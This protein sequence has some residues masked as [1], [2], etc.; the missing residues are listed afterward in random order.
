MST[1]TDPVDIYSPDWYASG[2][3]HGTF[4]GLRRQGAVHWQDMPDEPGFWAVLRHAELAHVAKHPELFSA[5][6]Q[7]IMLEDL[8]PEQLEMVRHML[9]AMDPPTHTAYRRPI[10]PHFTAK[11]IS[12]MED[13]VRARCRGILDRVDGEVDLV[14]DVAGP[15]P[16]QMITDIMG[17]PE[18]DTD[19][20]Q[21]WAELMTGGQDSELAGDYDGNASIDMAMYAIEFAARRRAEPRRDDIT[22][23][24]LETTYE[25]GRPMSDID[26]GSFFVQL[27]TA[28]NDTT[29][30]SMAAGTLELIR[31]PDEQA[32]LRGDPG[33]I[34]GAV[35]EI[36]RF[37]NPLH[38]FRRT[39]VVDT[40]LG[41]TP[42]RAGD[43]VAMLYTSAN[44]DELV[45]ADP[46]RFDVRRSPNPHLSFGLGAHFCLGA[47]LARLEIRVFLEELLTTFPVL[48]L[49]GEPVR[50]RS[51]LN[52]GY[53]HIPVRLA[54]SAG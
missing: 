2:D 51:N 16:A 49:A 22:S 28:G 50:I 40:E 1:R 12:A 20:I 44:R 52:N 14:H 3:V 11:V 45:F 46:Q 37:C 48:E 6:T 23:L 38:Y 42:I 15:L 8:A 41:G 30:T 43:K 9:L 54:R 25:D 18:E 32:L 53:R 7:G 27:V 31:H 19:R 33:L 4:A 34:P 24:L 17:L 26:F 36:V 35:E 13:Q 29:K 5:S 21:R 47:H 39:A 10:S